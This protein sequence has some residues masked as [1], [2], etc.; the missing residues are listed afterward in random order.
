MRPAVRVA[1]ALHSL[2]DALANP[3]T[4]A[5]ALARLR[6]ILADPTHGP[7]SR[8]DLRDAL[9][10]LP[11]WLQAV[12]RE[13]LGTTPSTLSKAVWRAVVSP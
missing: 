5:T 1:Q 2:R 9:A 10:A 12:A 3:A 6:T 8:D 13:L 7:A 11:I 4:R